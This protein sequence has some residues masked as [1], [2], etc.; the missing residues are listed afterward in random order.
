MLVHE[1]VRGFQ[2]QDAVAVIDAVTSAVTT[3]HGIAP[4]DVVLVRPGKV[5][6]TTSG[7]VRRGHCRE[8][9]RNGELPR[10]SPIGQPV[11]GSPAIAPAIAEIL[12]QVLHAS[13]ESL[14]PDVP[15]IGIG[16]DSLRATRLAAALVAAFGAAPDLTEL[17]DELTPRGLNEWASTAGGSVGSP[18]PDA[19]RAAVQPASSAQEWLWL[20]DR[21]GAGPA[22]TIAGGVHLRGN[23]DVERLRLAVTTVLT[24]HPVLATTFRLDE[25]GTLLVTRTPG[26]PVPLPMVDVSGDRGS[27]ATAVVSELA[28]Q[29]F[30]LAT[31]PLVRAVLVRSDEHWTVGVAAHHI[32]V[33]GWSLAI[34]LG[35]LGL[36]YHD[37]AGVQR[38]RG[39]AVGTGPGPCAGDIEFWHST[40]DG[41]RAAALPPD[42]PLAG[43]RGWRGASTPLIL[44]APLVAMVKAYAAEHRATPFM[45]LLAALAGLLARRTGQPDLVVGTPAARRDGA[46]IDQVGLFVNTLPIRIDASGDPAFAEL[47][48][49]VR[50]AALAAYRHQNLPFEKIL[51]SADILDPPGPRAPLV[52]VCLAVQDLPFE[53]W[54]AGGLIAEPFELPAAGAQFEFMVNLAERPDGSMSG[55][56]VHAADLFWP[57]TVAAIRDELVAVLAAVTGGDERP[58]ARLPAPAAP[59]TDHL[60]DVAAPAPFDLVSLSSSGSRAFVEARDQVEAQLAA[61]WCEVIELP[62]VSVAAEFFEL[63]GHS[64]QAARIVARIETSFGVRVCVEELLTAEMTIEKLA[65][66]VRDSIARAADPDVQGV[67]A[68][69]VQLSDEE[70]AD[71]L[72]SESE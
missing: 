30:D 52:R 43:R 13:P 1:V 37:P 59:R 55:Y 63:G 66:V 71:L 31:G 20:L 68:D 67:L 45:V 25:A 18:Q 6:T 60:A 35:D 50:A 36:A 44:P 22:Y 62:Q 51:S 56:T 19:V 46:T 10:L 3:E 61:I 40:L 39:R 9:W 2:A 70:I 64:L 27:D 72:G 48:R 32:A 12:G 11:G 16:L 69:L 21:M 47:V 8:L 38:A 54:P 7:K 17:L 42:R 15:L 26:T 58:L 24:S 5:P 65:A 28:S 23:V 4:H 29:G 33:D 14:A 57:T 41:A 34:L 53:P 49:R